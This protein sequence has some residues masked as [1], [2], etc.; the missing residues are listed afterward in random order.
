[1]KKYTLKNQFFIVFLLALTFFSSLGCGFSRKTRD[2]AQEE[3]QTLRD[4]PVYA[5]PKTLITDYERMKEN[6]IVSWLWIKPGFDLNH[7]KTFTILP[8]KNYSH[9]SFPW[10]QEKLTRELKTVFTPNAS[11]TGKI[12]LGISAAIIDLIPKKKIFNQSIIPKI[13]VELIL[14]D[15]DTKTIYSRI[16][17]YHKAEEFKDALQGLV[18]DL[19][20]LS[21]KT[22]RKES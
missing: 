15:Q 13:S 8:V 11:N 4:T 6:S 18:N 7:C 9:V 14:F 10:A 12:N 17:H 1:M 3:F 20:T 19:K 21:Q 16:S 22:L 2:S 5:T